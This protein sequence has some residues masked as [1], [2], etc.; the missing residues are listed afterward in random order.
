MEKS[1]A[2]MCVKTI[3]ILITIFE[4]LSL[5]YHTIFDKYLSNRISIA[6]YCHFG[7]ILLFI[8]AY[9]CRLMKRIRHIQKD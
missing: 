1:S 2:K 3:I 4:L 6:Y 8:F 9:K 5:Y 7:V